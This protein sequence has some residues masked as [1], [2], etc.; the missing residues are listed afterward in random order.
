MSDSKIFDQDW[1]EGIDLGAGGVQ[2]VLEVPVIEFL[3]MVIDTKARNE[4]YGEVFMLNTNAETKHCQKVEKT[5]TKTNL[6]VRHYMGLRA[7]QISGTFMS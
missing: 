2:G 7:S 1:E 4:S 6:L 5:S 3:R